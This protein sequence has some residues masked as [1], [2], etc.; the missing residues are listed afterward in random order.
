MIDI[1]AVT[2][3]HQDTVERWHREDVNN[4]YEG[5]LELACQQ[6]A[7]NFLLFSRKKASNFCCF[8]ATF[9]AFILTFGTS[10][11]SRTHIG[12]LSVAHGI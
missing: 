8:S 7:F 1:A 12:Q 3:M 4:P 2:R 5:I 9:V 6:H 11:G 10:G